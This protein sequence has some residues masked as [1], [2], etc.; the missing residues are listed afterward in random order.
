MFNTVSDNNDPLT[1]IINSQQR[2][3]KPQRVAPDC[4]LQPIRQGHSKLQVVVRLRR[5]V[6]VEDVPALVRTAV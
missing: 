6:L 1:S 3:R 4:G 2:Q 5:T